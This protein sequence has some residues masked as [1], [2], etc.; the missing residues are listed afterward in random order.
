MPQMERRAAATPLAA[1]LAETRDIVDRIMG[2]RAWRGVSNKLR[3]EGLED[4]TYVR[5][6]S[7]SYLVNPRTVAVSLMP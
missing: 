5:I 2:R 3:N 4:S 1:R 6:S 7:T